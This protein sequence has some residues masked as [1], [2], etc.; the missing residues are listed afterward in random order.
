[1][2]G[3]SIHLF[4][5]M[6]A[7]LA[8][9]KGVSPM[10]QSH[11]QRGRIR[12]VF[13][14]DTHLG[15]KHSRAGELLSF[16]ESCDPEFLYLVGDI[17]DGWRLRRVW[18]WNPTYDAILSRLITLSQKKTLVRYTPG[19]HD[20]F[21][22]AFLTRVG[23]IELSDEFVHVTSDGRRFLITH[24]D[25][26]DVFETKASLVC[27]LATFGYDVLLN[28]NR[29]LNKMRRRPDFSFAAAVKQRVKTLV[30]FVSDFEVSLAVHAQNRRCDG[31]VCGHVHHPAQRK[32]GKITYLN[33]GD[34]VEHC[35]ALLEYECG[36][37][38]LVSFDGGERRTIAVDAP[39][40]GPVFS[41]AE[42]LD[43]LPVR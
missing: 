16:L 38:E 30:R 32:L 27:I 2:V 39:D 20:R 24:G 3:F 11:A 19:N 40:N 18:R 4:D 9:A 14:S 41:L 12:S 43:P 29:L 31:V 21:L 34:W 7:D 5:D 17:I 15:C 8:S 10:Q 13:V 6:T 22:R 42:E 1:M 25:R 36:T 28:V 26:F 37:L 35:T 23:R 33:T